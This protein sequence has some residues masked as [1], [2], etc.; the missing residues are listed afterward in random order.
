MTLQELSAAFEEEA[1][2]ARRERLLLSVAVTLGKND[3]E[4]ASTVSK[5]TRLV[6]YLCIRTSAEGHVSSVLEQQQKNMLLVCSPLLGLWVILV[7]QVSS[8][9]FRSCYSYH[10]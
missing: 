8:S 1:L 7:I 2:L 5:I 4:D 10:S 6:T 9:N 3:T